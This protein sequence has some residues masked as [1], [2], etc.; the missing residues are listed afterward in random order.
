MRF[1]REIDN[2]ARL[3]L[4]QQAC[5]QVGIADVAVHKDMA[6]VAC[7]RGEV[8][9]VAS[10][11]QLVQVEH[12]L[13]GPGQPVED[14]IATDKTGTSGHQDHGGLASSSPWPHGAARNYRIAPTADQAR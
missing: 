10:V 1:R 12:G 3:V 4:L 11:G 8:F 7:Q 13:I 9:P 14:K 5:N 6:R 2:G